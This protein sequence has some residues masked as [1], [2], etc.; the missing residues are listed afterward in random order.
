[1][2]RRKHSGDRLQTLAH[3]MKQLHKYVS[4]YFGNHIVRRR[5]KLASVK[6]AG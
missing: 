2:K 5:A 1:M 4:D 6:H 3:P